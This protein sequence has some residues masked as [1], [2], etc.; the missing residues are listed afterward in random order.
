MRSDEVKIRIPPGAQPRSLLRSLGLTDAEMDLPFIGIAN[1]YNS[2][3]PGHIH[4]RQLAEK[5]REGIASG[6]G[7]VRF[8]VLLYLRWY[9]NGHEGMR[10][11]LP[12]RENIGRFY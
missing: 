1:A 5:V 8:R 6:G 3:V 10:Y 11:S 2:I 7:P 4:L 9:S 12:S